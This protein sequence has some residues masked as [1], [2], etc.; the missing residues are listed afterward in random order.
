MNVQLPGA[1][2]R[3]RCFPGLLVR[4]TIRAPAGACRQGA[5]G[6]PRRTLPGCLPTGHAPRAPRPPGTGPASTP[7]RSARPA[8][9]SRN[10]VLPCSR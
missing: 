6:A 10:Q 8:G 7:A 9:V 3:S 1:C 5:V 4:S 2:W